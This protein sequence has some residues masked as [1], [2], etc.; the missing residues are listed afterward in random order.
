MDRSG[1]IF[2]HKTFIFNELVECCQA[3]NLDEQIHLVDTVLNV[4]PIIYQDSTDQQIWNELERE[5]Y[6]KYRNRIRYFVT[7]GFIN[8]FFRESEQ[9]TTFFQKNS[10]TPYSEEDY[11]EFFIEAYSLLTNIKTLLYIAEPESKG[12]SKNSPDA[13]T[14]IASANAEGRHKIFDSRP[15]QILLMYYLTKGLGI[16]ERIDV[17][18]S[19]IAKFYHTLIGWPF[20]DINNSQIYKLLKKAPNMKTDKKQLYIDLQWVRKQIEPLKLMAVLEL[21]DKEMKNLEKDVF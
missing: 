21:I 14:L 18:I 15:Q 16:N 3:L 10:L 2:K 1:I 13:S 19:T 8:H 5:L 17:S 4:L 11:Q 12:L 7:S 9:L 20:I 6:V